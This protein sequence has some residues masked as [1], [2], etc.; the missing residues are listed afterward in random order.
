M[1]PFRALSART[2]FRV[3]M[4]NEE[5]DKERAG[6]S[7]EGEYSTGCCRKDRC[8]VRACAG[9]VLFAL[10][11]IVIA[12][13]SGVLG[14]AYSSKIL[15][16]VNLPF[17]SG[18][19]E[20]NTMTRVVEERVV[21]ED[22][23]IIDLVEKSSPAVVSIVATKDVPKVRNVGPFGG[24]PFFF[25][26]DDPYRSQD[27]NER[28]DATEKRRVGSGTGFLVSEDGLIVTNKHV[29]SDE[30]AEYTVLLDGG[31]EYKA[32]VLARDPAHDLAVIR[33]EGS[34]FPTISLG[35]SDSV[36]VGQTV[37]AIGNS[38]GE[39]SNSV[40][41]GIVSGLGRS[42]TAGSGYGDAETLT[43]IIQTDA[44]INPGNSGGP[45][46]D[47][48]GHVIGINV[49][50]A[51]GAQSV[52]FAIPVNQIRRTVEDVKTTGKISTPYIGVRYAILDE[53]AQKEN[54]LPFAY[55]AIVLRGTKPTEFAVIP[56]S[57]ADKAGIVEND[58]ILEINGQ[59]IDIDHPLGNIIATY[60]P[61]D[62]VT[63][64]LWHKGEDKEVKV[65][66]EERK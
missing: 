7:V 40:S 6:V 42:V 1:T 15:P 2:A 62:E 35:D 27:G 32:T 36:K 29:V 33:I 16:L 4:E 28:D 63:L 17:L 60:R 46:L 66:L 64:K 9:R 11:V 54:S 51:Q 61:G 48:S 56:G 52:G 13:V 65:I 21:Q 22:S 19:G 50:V 12:A 49:A 14:A 55:G 47:V 44:A 31:K 25:F 57:P 24:F 39:F 18:S 3:S 43:G 53:V 37:I 26:Q 5:N 34:G 10:G 23:L 45:L 58:I 38:L 20:E 41:R 8:R 30:A 59:K